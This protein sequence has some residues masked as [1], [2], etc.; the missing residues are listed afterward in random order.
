MLFRYTAEFRATEAAE[1]DS[2]SHSDAAVHESKFWERTPVVL[3]LHSKRS[4]SQ[5]PAAV[6]IHFTALSL[7]SQTVYITLFNPLLNRL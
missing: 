3:L 1:G 2:L 6:L 5:Q 4:S 7:L